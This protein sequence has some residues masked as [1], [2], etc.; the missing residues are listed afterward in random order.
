MITPWGDIGVGML[1]W[2]KEPQKKFSQGNQAGE[3]SRTGRK[4]ERDGSDHKQSITEAFT[5]HIVELS[6]WE[7][8]SRQTQKRHEGRSSKVPSAGDYLGCAKDL[9]SGGGE[10]GQAFLGRL[11][12]N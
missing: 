1:K 7:G 10:R 3:T 8:W 11:K 6:T 12:Q 4:T 5:L 2:N 9:T